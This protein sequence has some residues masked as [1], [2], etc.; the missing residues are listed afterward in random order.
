LENGATCLHE[1]S[2]AAVARG[3][4][5]CAKLL[6]EFGQFRPS[7]WE[8][9]T[10]AAEMGQLEM[11]KWLRSQGGQWHASLVYQMVC[12]AHPCNLGADRRAC[13]EWARAN[14]YDATVP[15]VDV[16]YLVLMHEMYREDQDVQTGELSALRDKFRLIWGENWSNWSN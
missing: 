9:C 8:C 7:D 5:D 14:G 16:A 11:L 1:A 12:H 3:Y 10:L 2:R 13:I 6:V 15:D 4:V